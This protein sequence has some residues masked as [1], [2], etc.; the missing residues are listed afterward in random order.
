MLERRSWVIKTG[1][2]LEEKEDYLVR[3]WRDQ[4]KAE[5]HMKW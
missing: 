1:M 4:L 2:V 3:W 5:E